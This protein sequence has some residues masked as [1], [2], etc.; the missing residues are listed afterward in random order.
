M[1]DGLLQ[2]GPDDALGLLV[3]FCS[4]NPPID[5]AIVE[6]A[7]AQLRAARAREAEVGEVIATQREALFDASA[8]LLIASVREPK[9]RTVH[10][11]VSVSIDRFPDRKLEHE[12][13]PMFAALGAKNAE[14]IRRLCREA[15]AE[16]LDVFPP[17]DHTKPDGSCAG[18]E[19]GDGA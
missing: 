1:G 7:A 4:L 10:V 16:G 6:R 3:D 19:E 15:R 17:C 13:L 11:A 5:R 8:D 9:G 14:D 18:H 12:Y 2:T